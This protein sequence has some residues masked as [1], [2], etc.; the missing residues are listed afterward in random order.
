[1]FRKQ[2]SDSTSH[3]R[4]MLPDITHACNGAKVSDRSAAILINAILKI[5]WE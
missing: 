4:T 1:M 5:M 2:D 3:M